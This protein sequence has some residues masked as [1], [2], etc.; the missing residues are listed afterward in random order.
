[1]LRV[2]IAT[3]RGSVSSGTNADGWRNVNASKSFRDYG[4]NFKKYV[5]A[6]K[7]KLCDSITSGNCLETLLVG[8]L[9]PL[10]NSSIVRPIRVGTVLRRIIGEAV[11]CLAKKY[12]M[13]SLPDIQMYAGQE[14]DSEAD[15]HTMID[16]T[17]NK[18]ERLLI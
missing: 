11:V 5:A 13:S 15:I 9:T 18:K 3:K 6:M 10:D 14:S 2:A 12:V 1:M 4:E 7:Q 17:S 8:P 16:F